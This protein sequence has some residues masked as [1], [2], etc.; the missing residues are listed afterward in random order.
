M[1]KAQPKMIAYRFL[2]QAIAT[3]DSPALV[4]RDVS[5]SYSQVQALVTAYALR[6]QAE[7]LG[8]SRSVR[9]KTDDPAVALPALMAAALLGLRV[10]AG[11]GS[12]TAQ[13]SIV[14][15]APEPAIQHVL[16]D[17]SFSPARLKASD[18]RAVWTQQ[19]TDPE[20]PWLH[21][22]GS[23][24]AQPIITLGQ[25]TVVDRA[26]SSLPVSGHERPRTAVLFPVTSYHGLTRRLATLY[27]GGCVIEATSW[28]FLADSGATDVIVPSAAVRALV[29]GAADAQLATGCE[30]VGL[31]LAQSDLEA[32]LRR[33]STVSVMLD[34]AETGSVLSTTTTKSDWTV[35]TRR[36]LL[37]QAEIVDLAGAP[38]H[39][40]R[41]RLKLDD[42]T[43][44]WFLPGIAARRTDDAPEVL[45]PANGLD[46][47]TVAGHT[48]D[49]ELLDAVITATEGVTQAVAFASPK[50][51]HDEILTFAVFEDGVN[52]HHVAK[53]VEDACR[54]A[55][56]AFA[57]PA[58]IRPIDA[59]PRLAD[60]RPDR[61]I[62]AAMILRAAQG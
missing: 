30:V 38:A 54:D 14:T 42:A 1:T 13:V 5:F 57:I 9:I 11:L 40:G 36:T 2:A 18:S 41:L 48:L 58:R 46:T 16:V 49:A 43:S 20:D 39:L 44:S 60:G 37:A 24:L 22:P 59:I 62:C 17:Q 10:D 4:L 55:F 21:C 52:R 50:P 3:P 15:Q 34:L 61:A 23:T 32:L 12:D 8:P 35:E 33:F 51:G 19:A 56:G 29:A 7:G 6:F 45:G 47:L 25:G 27:S 26:L 53:R 31:R 28:G